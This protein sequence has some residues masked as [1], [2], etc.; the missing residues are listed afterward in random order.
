MVALLIFGATLLVA[1][2][3]SALADRS[4]ISAAVLFLV[5]GFV[6]GPGVAGILADLHGPTVETVSE[7]TLFALLLTD[8][9][10]LHRGEL[11]TH[12]RMSAL[13]L[14]VGVPVTAAAIAVF[15]HW[16][17]GFSWLEA[18]L[19]GAVLS[20]TDPVLA[21]A[22]IGREGVSRRLRRLLNVESGLNDGL[23][24]PAVLL[25]LAAVGPGRA[26]AW[27]IVGDL[28]L[29]TVLGI[30]LPWVVVRLE[31]SRLF[32]ARLGYRPILV[33]ATGIALFALGRI[34]GA[35][36]FFAAFAAGATF[37]T[38]S[39]GLVRD[40]VVVG[41]TVTEVLKLAA[42]FL[43]GALF[44]RAIGSLS[45]AVVGFA[46]LSLALA[47]PIALALAGAWR[48]LPWREW[49]SAAWFGPRGFASVT[50]GIMVA[51]SGGPRGLAMA[52]AVA[53]VVALSI[54]LHSSTDV[55]V[56]KW[57]ERHEP[58]SEHEPTR[59]HRRDRERPRAPADASEPP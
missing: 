20:P 34:T 30:A 38:I 6:C 43:F 47:R 51:T 16:V 53:V 3:V 2:L 7:V 19:V 24:L 36:E 1:V 17:V 31:A 39:P 35:N 37:A 14:L 32:E 55:V 48:W 33:L 18:L 54:L 56:A 22:L 23:A 45:W 9:L 8:A 10:H 21:S 13:A 15:A 49:L 28:A 46:V 27:R 44:S 12:W 59:P 57:L 42:I 5:V 40:F 50:Y 52:Q 41:D 4:I 11:V 29:G 25:L 26:S 58:P